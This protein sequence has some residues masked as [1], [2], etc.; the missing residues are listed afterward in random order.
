MKNHFHTFGVPTQNNAA[1]EH[2][3]AL[4]L[5]SL[6]GGKLEREAVI[7]ACDTL[8]QRLSGEDY[9]NLLLLSG[10]S[11]A[12]AETE[13]ALARRMF[14]RAYLEERLKRELGGL[15]DETFLPLDKEGPVRLE[16]R[17]LGVLLH[18]P[19]GNA[20]A[21]PVYSVIEGLL[22][23]NINILKLPDGGDALSERILAELIELEP[24]I[25]A[26]VFV[27]RLASSERETMERLAA[28]ADAIVVWGGDEAVASVRRLA[29]PDT[30]IIEWGHKISFAYVSGE[31][32]DD[33]E[34]DGIAQNIC[35]TNQ[36]LCSSCQGIFV[37]TEDFHKVAAFAECFFKILDQRAS[38][39][40]L[41]Y[42]LFRTAQLTLELYTEELEA[43]G[44]ERAV[45]K[46]AHCAVIAGSDSALAPSR[47][48]R[49]VW[50]KPLPRNRILFELKKHKSHLQTAALL[51]GPVDRAELEELL[52][53][54]G[55]VRLTRGDNMSQPYCGMPHDGEFALRRYVRA[56]TREF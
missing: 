12:K 20:D 10:L 13:L 17:P 11:R 16:W 51:C 4:V 29:K 1:L 41:P 32:A 46:S 31:S 9:L 47:L 39:D 36:L 34:L 55:V 26:K 6:A 24:R 38:T 19:A 50:I 52:I 3:G 5:D 7:Q 14:S 2:L 44:K 28:L 56:V 21:L 25:S 15:K 42:D 27:F 30:R 8:S 37:D 53:L 40:P 49:T 35:Q 54:A 33:A 22:T 18:L 48:F 23:E 45:Y 43:V